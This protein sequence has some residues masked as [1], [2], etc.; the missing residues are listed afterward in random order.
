M[1]FLALVTKAEVVET[2]TSL[3]RRCLSLAQDIC[4]VVTFLV[5]IETSEITQ[6]LA[7][8]TGNVGGIN[9]GGW[10]RVFSRSSSSLS[11]VILSYLYVFW[12]KASQPITY[13][14][15]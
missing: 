4:H 7:S 1:D 11:F 14:E 8:H 12:I 13:L 9:I 3:L 15:L 10:G 6:I 2:V 5:A